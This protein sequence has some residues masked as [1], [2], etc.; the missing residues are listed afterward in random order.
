MRENPFT[1][2]PQFKLLISG[3]HKPHLRSVNEATR[4]RFLIIPFTVTIP[5]AE[6]DKDLDANSR[7][8]HPES[9]TGPYKGV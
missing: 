7:P 2:R 8:R 3:N 5:P 6:R 9:S 4:R 1:F